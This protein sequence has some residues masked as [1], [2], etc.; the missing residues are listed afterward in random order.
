M[1][2]TTGLGRPISALAGPHFVTRRPPI[3]PML[4]QRFH[5]RARLLADRSGAI[6]AEFAIVVPILLL[7]TFSIIEF[8]RVMWTRNVLQSAVE[9]AARCS[10]LSRPECDTV[11]EL[12]SYAVSKSAGLPVPAEAFEIDTAAC[13]TRVV[14]T[15][16]FAAIVPIIPLD[17][18]VDARACRATPP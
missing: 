12:Q 16:S 1:A 9:D 5:T 2:R 17:F 3:Y 6:A 7:L 4:R 18:D 14:A 10:A 8:G 15:Y 11:A 13:G